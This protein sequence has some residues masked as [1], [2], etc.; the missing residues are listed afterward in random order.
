MRERSSVQKERRKDNEYVTSI[1]F[2]A[3]E[4]RQRKLHLIHHH[5]LILPH[6]PVA[7]HRPHQPVMNKRRNPV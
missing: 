4:S 2:P 3:A 1:T 6:P 7:A 5:Q